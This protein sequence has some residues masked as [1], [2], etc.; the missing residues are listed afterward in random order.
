[1]EELLALFRARASEIAEECDAGKED[2]LEAAWADLYKE[3]KR[4]SQPARCKVCPGRTTAYDDGMVIGTRLAIEKLRG[5]ANKTPGLCPEARTLILDHLAT[6]STPRTSQSRDRRDD[7]LLSI[8]GDVRAT[9]K[10]LYHRSEDLQAIDVKILQE[11]LHGWRPSEAEKGD[12]W[13]ETVRGLIVQALAATHPTDQERAPG[14]TQ[15]APRYGLTEEI[16]QLL[17]DRQVLREELAALAKRL[18]PKIAK[19]CEDMQ[20]FM[21]EVG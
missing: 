18:P 14:A 11:A 9:A 8:A 16:I 1:V 7:G 4:L 19:L 20:A 13:D 10:G 17:K 21:D 2:R 5:F 12:R 3:Y 15:E 6:I